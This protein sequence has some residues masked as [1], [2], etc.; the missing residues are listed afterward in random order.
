MLDSMLIQ[1]ET[2][3]HNAITELVALART[4]IESAAE[5]DKERA[6]ALAI[7]AE[8]R[9]KAIAC[10]DARRTELE[11]DMEAMHT[12]KEQHEGRVELNIGGVRFETSVQTLRRVRGTFFDAYSV[13]GS[14]R[15]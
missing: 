13:A 5:V 12:H 1:L 7:V 6:K 11:R 2:H 4:Q 14:R 9:A 3:L 15:N 10:V 8:Q